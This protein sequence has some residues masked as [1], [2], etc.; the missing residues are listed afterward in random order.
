MGIATSPH[1]ASN[2]AVLEV[3][4]RCNAAACSIAAPNTA[5]ACVPRAQ[6]VVVDT[7]CT[8]AQHMARERL[9]GQGIAFARAHAAA[10]HC[11][12]ASSHALYRIHRHRWGAASPTDPDRAVQALERLVSAAEAVI[13]GTLSPAPEVRTAAPCRRNTRRDP[14]QQPL[15]AAQNV[16]VSAGLALCTTFR[17]IQPRGAVAWPAVSSLLST[18]PSHGRNVPVDVHALLLVFAAT[19]CLY[20]SPAKR[21]LSNP[22]TAHQCDPR[23]ADSITRTLS[24]TPLTLPSPL[25]LVTPGGMPPS[26]PF[27]G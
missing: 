8:V 25:P 7:A 10:F 24:H 5:P 16:L 1:H 20:P 22:D 18:M 6:W 14:C 12:E 27:A 9:H 4:V 15:C 2:E 17:V 26:S 13:D 19:A 21:D 23:S 11:V 3:A